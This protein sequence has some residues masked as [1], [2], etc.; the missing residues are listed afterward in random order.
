M[1]RIFSLGETVLDIIFKQG[2]PVAAKA[3]GSMLNASVT[4]GRLGLPVYFISEFGQDQV[5]DMVE[6]FLQSNGVNTQYCN[7]Y[8]DGKSAIA[9]AF[10][11]ENQNA[12]YSFYKQYP[13]ERL[14]IQ[15]PGFTQDDIFM[16]GSFFSIAPEIRNTVLSLLQSAREAGA[17]I[18]YDPNFRKAHLWHKNELF[19]FI[20]ENLDFATVI[21]GS[22]ED[23]IN[24]FN[25]H[26]P[27]EVFKNLPAAKILIET[28]GK[29][30]VEFVAKSLNFN[31]PAKELIAISTVGAGDNFNAGMAFGMFL[32]NVDSRNIHT[33]TKKDWE[34]ILK[35]GIDFASEVCLSLDNYISIDYA[36][37]YPK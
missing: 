15:F 33:F 23:F 2:E 6:N 13:K 7:R 36:E 24:I 32:K 16:F 28:F 17:L 37:S 30:G 29:D 5:G 14:K 18:Y 20:S 34:E 4:L 22:D 19:P 31:I 8:K 25:T 27:Q 21:K 9:L 11:D 10:L 1:R 26:K 12:D 35:I 3:G